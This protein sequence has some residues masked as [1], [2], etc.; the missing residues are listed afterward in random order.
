[1]SEEAQEEAE[2]AVTAT[3]DSYGGP[4]SDEELA[5]V[6]LPSGQEQVRNTGIP[7]GPDEP[8]EGSADIAE[9]APT[10]TVDP[11]D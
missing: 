7:A 10:T 1:M 4:V 6:Y 11:P 2:A 8:A 9:A 5:E 3:T